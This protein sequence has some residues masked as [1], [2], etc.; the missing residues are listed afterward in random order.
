MFDEYCKVPYVNLYCSHFISK[1]N[2]K[3]GVQYEYVT[4][5]F[6]SILPFTDYNNFIQVFHKLYIKTFYFF[7]FA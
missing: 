2:I 4:Y 5:N 1:N 3:I 6:V 7:N